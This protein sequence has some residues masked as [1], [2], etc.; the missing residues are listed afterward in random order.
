MEKSNSNAVF[1]FFLIGCGGIAAIAFLIVAGFI[2]WLMM[3]PESGVKLPHQMDSYAVK[4]LQDHN[5][6]EPDEQVLAYFDATMSMDGSE[7]AILT[8]R[9]LMH[10][11]GG[12]TTSVR[13]DE[14]VDIRHRK[15]TLIGDIIEA[16]DSSGTII[17]IE[18][19]PLNNGETFKN[20]TMTAWKK[21]KNCPPNN[22]RPSHDEPAGNAYS[23]FAK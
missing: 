15:E 5:M 17:M 23:N 22:V 14:V 16:E 9:R 12:T 3:Q 18:I 13:L 2:V 11:I 8:N 10:H 19:A 20:A 7:A 4:Y 21:E 1:K 6:L